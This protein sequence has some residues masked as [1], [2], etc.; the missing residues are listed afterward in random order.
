M[1]DTALQVKKLDLKEKRRERNHEVIRELLDTTKA[2]ATSPIGLMILASIA[3]QKM[4]NA[5]LF[6]PHDPN[7]TIE[8]DWDAGAA[9]SDWL[10]FATMTVAACM[11]AKAAADVLPSISDFV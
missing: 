10:F 1:A 9:V 3:N 6:N 7:H 4:Y 2:A 5:G 8:Q 11:A